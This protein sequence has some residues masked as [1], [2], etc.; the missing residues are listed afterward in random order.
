[1]TLGLEYFSLWLVG[2]RM[3]AYFLEFSD[4]FD[5]YDPDYFAYF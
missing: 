2:V 5:Y 3:Y 1:V 4:L